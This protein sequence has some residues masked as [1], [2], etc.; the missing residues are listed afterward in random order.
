MT[1]LSWTI[2]GG[3]SLQINEE[4]FKE[5]LQYVHKKQL[6]IQGE[7]VIFSDDKTKKL[8]ELIK[9]NDVLGRKI[10][11]AQNLLNECEKKYSLEKEESFEK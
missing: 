6:T 2:N 11:Q 5:F 4:L 7:N 8:M 3:A 9:E 1:D 10:K